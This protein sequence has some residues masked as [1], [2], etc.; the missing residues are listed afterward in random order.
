MDWMTYTL[1]IVMLVVSFAFSYLAIF[2]KQLKATYIVE[3]VLWLLL[4]IVVIDT[5]VSSDLVNPHNWMVFSI[6]LAT[7]GRLVAILKGELR[8]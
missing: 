3:V 6:V 4:I 7:I 2:T 8:K 5:G 1:G